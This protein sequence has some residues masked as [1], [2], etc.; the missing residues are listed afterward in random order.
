MWVI[1]ADYPAS[2]GGVVRLYLEVS[3]HD[4]VGL[5]QRSDAK[6]FDKVGVHR[7]LARLEA[8][9]VCTLGGLQFH[10]ERAETPP[11]N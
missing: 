9:M 1:Y 7:A 8:M 10:A 2:N 5:G 11:A 6:E 4:S 3:I